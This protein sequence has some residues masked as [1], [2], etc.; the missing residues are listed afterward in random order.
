[1]LF[2][3]LNLSLLFLQGGSGEAGPKGGPGEK[4]PDGDPGLRGEQGEDGDA[5]PPVRRPTVL[6]IYK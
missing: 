3:S 4:G 2:S 6:T 1:M 5:G